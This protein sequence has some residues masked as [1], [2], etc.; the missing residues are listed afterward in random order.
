VGSELRQH[1]ALVTGGGRGIGRAICLRLAA[2]GCRVAALARAESELQETVAAT[3]PSSAAILPIVG[4][5]TND[6][7]L[8]RAVDTVGTQLGPLT[9]LVNNAG[10]ATPR[11]AI[12]DS[13][14]ADWDR[15]IATC[16]RAPMMLT[17]LVLPGMLERRAGIIVNIASIAAKRGR[18]GEAAYAAA[19]FGVLGFTQSLQEE[20]AQ[21][22]IKVTAICPG[23]V[24]TALI[25][26]NA[27][28][29][30]A[31]FL[32]PADVAEVVYQV[33]ISPR[34]TCPREIV[35]EPQQGAGRD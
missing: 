12:V 31:L 16:L 10:F 32:K 27:K 28:V 20:V 18:A 6:T 3:A 33:V 14:P 25:P 4:D 9:I 35:I 15:T 24:D 11:R 26:P 29:D 2:G 17:R 30:R 13:R 19:K 34:H 23:L 1:I 22:G 8:K 7:D 21:R 5:V